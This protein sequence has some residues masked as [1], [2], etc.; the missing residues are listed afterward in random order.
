[1]LTKYTPQALHENSELNDRAIFDSSTGKALVRHVALA[2]R[3]MAL[4]N[5]VRSAWYPG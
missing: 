2:Y 4:R 3:L 1:M 5:R